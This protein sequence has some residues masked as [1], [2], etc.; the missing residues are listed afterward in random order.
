[1][2]EIVVNS[3]FVACFKLSRVERKV[4]RD[5]LGYTMFH[6]IA[7]TGEKSRLLEYFQ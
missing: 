4:I 5:L 7:N 2:G 3:K 6:F 1:M